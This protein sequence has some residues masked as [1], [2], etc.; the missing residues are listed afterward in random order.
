MIYVTQTLRD[1]VLK[2]YHCYIQ[3]TGGDRLAYILTTVCRW[4]GVVDQSRKLCRI[5]K[6]C[7]K[8]K[9]CNA[10]YGLP[11]SKDAETLTPWHT[12]CVDLIITYN[13]LPKVRKSENK[14]LTKEL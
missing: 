1:R 11:P 13:I 10:K 3:H 12:V 14:I 4:S 7:Q 9:K 8:F 2:W 5:C 6:Q